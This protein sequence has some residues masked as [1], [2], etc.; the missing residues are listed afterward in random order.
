[1]TSFVGTA[2]YIPPEILN[3]LE[4]SSESDIW[5]FGCI[6]YQMF[7]GITPFADK[8]DYLTFQKINKCEYD[9]PNNIP[10][11]ARDLIS[12]MLKLKKEERI[13]LTDLKKHAYLSNPN[14]YNLEFKMIFSIEEVI[15]TGLIKKRSPW[16]HYNI[17]KV[18][19]FTTCKIKY[20]DP[21]SNKLKRIIDLT[22]SEVKSKDANKFELITQSKKYIFH[23]DVASDKNSWVDAIR[24]LIK[25][26]K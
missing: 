17:R 3:N 6:L 25:I 9:M 12:K 20:Y 18:S 1:M 24:D 19:L 16:F 15:K 21:T 14:L 13:T 11:D 2:D 4:I 26:Y 5:S 23:C 22:G 7:T 10:E 8:T